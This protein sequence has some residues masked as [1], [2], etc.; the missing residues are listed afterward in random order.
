M[1]STPFL[2]LLDAR[3]LLISTRRSLRCLEMLGTPLTHE[4]VEFGFS[5]FA[6]IPA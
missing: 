6:Y 1:N 2:V 3:R 5:V 4:R